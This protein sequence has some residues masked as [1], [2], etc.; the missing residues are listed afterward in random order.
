MQDHLI[1]FTHGQNSDVPEPLTFEFQDKYKI[2]L[3][4]LLTVFVLG[5][6]RSDTSIFLVCLHLLLPFLAL[7]P[8]L[9]NMVS[10][11]ASYEAQLS[12]C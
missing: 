7:L 3:N 9:R 8:L 10:F 12:K 2:F 5:K 1:R 6:N 11:S 4:L